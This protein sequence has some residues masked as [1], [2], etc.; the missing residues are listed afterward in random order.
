[1]GEGGK[2][3]SK[4]KTGIAQFLPDHLLSLVIRHICFPLVVGVTKN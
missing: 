3:D 4:E 2:R 1:M